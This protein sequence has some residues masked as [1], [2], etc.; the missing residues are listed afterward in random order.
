M[1][2]ATQKQ[3]PVVAVVDDDPVDLQYIE[4]GLAQ[5]SLVRARAV[6]CPTIEEA[7]KAV[8]EKTPLF[9]LLDAHLGPLVLAEDNI[10]R[11][12]D[13]GYAARI[14]VMSGSITGRRYEALRAFGCFEV[15]RKMSLALTPWRCW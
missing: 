7:I 6:L 8:Q 12:K 13:A 10:A 11:L 4:A 15:S 2:S 14:V 1:E 5:M 3:T 9:V